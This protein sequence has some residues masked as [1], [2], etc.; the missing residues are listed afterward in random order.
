MANK[1]N[2]IVTYFIVKKSL[3]KF[4][5]DDESIYLSDDVVNSSDF[6]KNPIKKGD[7]VEVIIDK[8]EV[9]GEKEDRV[10][11]LVMAS[12]KETKKEETK[13]EKK[14]ESNKKEKKSTELTKE[15][16]CVSQYGVKF[17]GDN[18][19]T[20]FTDELQKKDVKAMGVLAGNTITA[21]IKEGKIVNIKKVDK[22]KAETK[23]SAK[24]SSGS[25]RDENAMDKRTAL[26]NA[27]DTLSALI[28][29]KS[30]LV[31]GKAPLEE[32]IETLA[33]VYY[34]VLKNL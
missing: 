15:V 19:W 25:Y 22:K 16:Y 34:K 31:D 13:E 7:E 24:S 30:S 9:D 18:N 3:I 26:M 20:N 21:E 6:E 17:V 32:S 33:K 1:V 8:V 29:I 5:G 23:S 10:T 2:K 12:K 4:D 27:K 14:P 11:S 28:A